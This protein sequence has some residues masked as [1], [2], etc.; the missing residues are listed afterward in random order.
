MKSYNTKKEEIKKITR[1]ENGIEYVYSLISSKSERVASF[2]IPLYSIEVTMIKDGEET[3][4][5]IC[6]IFSDIGKALSFLGMLAE[7]LATPID[8]TYILEDKITI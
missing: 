8:L 7:N 5:S 1:S 6:E 4:N 2:G 3:S